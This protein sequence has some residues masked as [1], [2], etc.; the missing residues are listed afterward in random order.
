MASSASSEVAPY[1]EE[2]TEYTSTSGTKSSSSSST[3]ASTSATV[4]VSTSTGTSRTSSTSDVCVPSTDPDLEGFDTCC[5][6]CPTCDGNS[7]HLRGLN[8]RKLQLGLPVECTLLWPYYYPLEDPCDGA[9]SSGDAFGHYF[10]GDGEGVTLEETG[11]VDSVTDY[12]KNEKE[13]I[14]KND[15]CAAI[16]AGKTPTLYSTKWSI[17]RPPSSSCHFWIGGFTMYLSNFQQQ[18]G[19]CNVSIELNMQ[20]WFSKPFDLKCGFPFPKD[21]WGSDIFKVEHTWTLDFTCP[22]PCD[23]PCGGKGERCCG[24]DKCE[25]NLKCIDG[26]CTVFDCIPG[27]CKCEIATPEHPDLIMGCRYDATWRIAH[28]CDDYI[29]K[30]SGPTDCWCEEYEDDRDMFP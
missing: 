17:S 23:P 25:G 11:L 6:E 28:S 21:I 19:T 18:F 8:L 7:R 16:K 30:S 24:L 2:T 13:Q 27:D 1:G 22:E 20:D 12:W 5:T 26:I 3:V 4:S 15:I 9:W 10:C 29:C 14:I